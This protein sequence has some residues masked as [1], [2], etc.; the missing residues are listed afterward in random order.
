MSVDAFRARLKENVTHSLRTDILFPNS[1]L[2]N[3]SK[4]DSLLTLSLRP[5]Y[6]A[7]P[8]A[9]YATVRYRTAVR[10]ILERHPTDTLLLPHQQW[11]TNA[12]WLTTYQK[13]LKPVLAAYIL[14]DA[15]G[16]VGRGVF[17]EINF[18]L[19]KKQPVIGNH[20]FAFT[21]TFALSPRWL[22]QQWQ[23]GI[24]WVQY[25]KLGIP[26]TNNALRQRWP[27]RVH[28][29][30]IATTSEVRSHG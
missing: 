10:P 11:C 17:D 24:D 21:P 6:L 3:S 29:T 8:R 1:A 7:A 16:F 19:R 27:A 22:L 23:G 30:P 20:V 12:H 15:N 13:T 25:A 18:L 2:R 5:I 14:A 9:T 4:L 28:P 26:R